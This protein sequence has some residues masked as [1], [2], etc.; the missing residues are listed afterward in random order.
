[1]D[2]EKTHY[3]ERTGDDVSPQTGDGMEPEQAPVGSGDNPDVGPITDTPGTG[4]SAFQGSEEGAAHDAGGKAHTGQD[5]GHPAGNDGRSTRDVGGPRAA[6]DAE[7]HEDGQSPGQ[8]AKGDI[9]T[10]GMD[11]HQ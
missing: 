3:A 10:K 4:D 7:R 2:D 6:E 8:G 1:M 9:Q 11:A 5:E